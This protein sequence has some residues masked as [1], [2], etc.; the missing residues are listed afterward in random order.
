MHPIK[1][2]ITV[3]IPSF[4]EAIQP[5]KPI[6]EKKSSVPDKKQ[7]DGIQFREAKNFAFSKFPLATALNISAAISDHINAAKTS[8]IELIMAVA[9]VNFEALFNADVSL[10]VAPTATIAAAAVNAS[11]PNTA[12]IEASC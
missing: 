10:E 9:M 5:L 12:L 3:I 8:N 6:L 4:R 11:P 1:A 2:A 7:T